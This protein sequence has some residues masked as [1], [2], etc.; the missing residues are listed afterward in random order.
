MAQT[1]TLETTVVQRETHRS[2]EIVFAPAES[3]RLVG[4]RTPIDMAEILGLRPGVPVRT[5]EEIQ[6]LLFASLAGRVY[7]FDEGSF[8]R[9]RPQRL[10]SRGSADALFAEQ[11]ATNDLVPVSSSPIRCASLTT[12][13]TQGSAWLYRVPTW[14][15]TVR[16]RASGFSCSQSLG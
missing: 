2:V 15:S 11:L 1:L 7:P 12:L 5:P 6:D 13:V 10:A 3:L 9:W 8:D 16:F 14:C 4:V